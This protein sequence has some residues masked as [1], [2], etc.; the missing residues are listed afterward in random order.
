MIC[1]EFS[2]R[3]GIDAA[4]SGCP[5]KGEESSLL[6]DPG[7]GTVGE[8]WKDDVDCETTGANRNKLSHYKLSS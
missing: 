5:S 7:T 6:T 2:V 8:A 3:T 4:L 1:A